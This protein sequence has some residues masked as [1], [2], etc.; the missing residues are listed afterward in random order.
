MLVAIPTLIALS[1]IL[2]LM[3]KAVPGDPAILLGTKANPE[4]LAKLRTELGLDQPL[5]VQ[6][7]SYIKDVFLDFDLGRSLTSGEKYLKSPG[8]N[9]SDSRACDHSNGT[10]SVVWNTPRLFSSPL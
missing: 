6:Y 5:L 4:A 9:P 3:I 7:G 2:F 8:R 10:R 1:L